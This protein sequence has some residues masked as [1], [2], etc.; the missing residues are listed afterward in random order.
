MD[1]A[2]SSAP[3]RVCF[4]DVISVRSNTTAPRACA[5]F[6]SPTAAR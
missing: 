2:D 3:V 1:P 4:T 6:A 5:A